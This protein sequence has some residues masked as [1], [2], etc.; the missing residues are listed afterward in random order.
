MAQFTNAYQVLEHLMANS[1][2]GETSMWG[3][4]KAEMDRLNEESTILKQENENL[5]TQLDQAQ[6][7]TLVA[8]EGTATV[9]EELL[10]LK[11]QI[12]GGTV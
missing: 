1:K 2:N 11:A 6:L 9:Y 8:L 3:L 7:D 4:I 10:L 12:E 5:K